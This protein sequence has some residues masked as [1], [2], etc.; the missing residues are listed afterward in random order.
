MKRKLLSILIFF[1]IASVLSGCWDRKEIETR[2]F[3][4]GIAIDKYPPTPQAEEKGA[5]GETPPKEEEK[6][7]EMEVH[8][9][10]D[11]YAMTVQI[12]IAKKTGV[13]STGGSG[14]TSDGRGEGANS[15]E[16]TQIGNS[17][18]SMNREMQSRTDL[19]LYYEHLQVIIL[20]DRIA[21]EG[22][23]NVIDFFVRDPE[24]RRVVKVFISEGQAKSILDVTPKIQDY[25]SVYL[26]KIPMNATKNSRMI[27]KT[28]LGEV[29]KSIHA[30]LDFVLP[31]VIATVDEIKT[32]G[33][34]AFKN[35]RMVGW[36]SEL[37]VEAIKFIQ[38]DYS[39]GVISIP[40]PEHEG[41]IVVMEVTSA[42]TKVKPVIQNN[43]L[44]FD[45]N[46]A[47]KGNYAENINM[48]THAKLSQE[49]INKLEKGYGKEIERI[50]K[51]TVSKM[52]EEYG[53][54]VFRF[55]QI[56]AAN[57]PAYWRKIE[58]KWD[59]VYPIVGVN[60]KAD[61]SIRLLGIVQ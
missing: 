51:Q 61:V 19:S 5:P 50:C 11:Q 23:E 25:S 49:L 40:S 27:S 60:I 29:I 54:D 43:E 9:G 17:F 53:A 39:G 10:K 59:S 46:I 21:R 44:S 31:K 36:V 35:G 7:E 24:M 42:Q 58:G 4:L 30:G 8:T 22:I 1:V 52:Q 45:I 41:G 6:L 57:E 2:G 48:H 56:L 26:N 20:S 15:W 18:M 55:G 32:S 37:E 33:G 47:V 12:P 13:S 34:A 16:I 14:G 38:N 3:V 28:D